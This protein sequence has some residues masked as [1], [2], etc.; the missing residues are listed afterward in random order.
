M[1]ISSGSAI[2]TA[3]GRSSPIRR[4]R[5]TS[6]RPGS[7]GSRTSSKASHYRVCLD[8]L[9]ARGIATPDESSRRPLLERRERGFLVNAGRLDEAIAATRAAVAR[10]DTRVAADPA[11]ERHLAG[12]WGDL[13]NLEGK[14]GRLTESRAAQEKSIAMFDRLVE[15]APSDA[16]LS[17]H[18]LTVL[19]N[20]ANS[21]AFADDAAARRA[22]ITTLVKRSGE[23]LDHFPAEPV[24][25]GRG[26]LL[27]LSLLADAEL[28]GGNA[29]A[30]FAHVERRAAMARRLAAEHPG[31][32]VFID[33]RV[34]A[35]VQGFHCL[36][37]LGRPGDARAGLEEAEA[38]AADAV[39]K[40]PS[41]LQRSW[42]L[43]EVL[44]VKAML[45]EA[46]GRRAEAL[47]EHRRLLDVILPW[48][49]DD[50]SPEP[51]PITSD[52]V[53]AQ[54]ERLEAE[55]RLASGAEE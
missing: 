37:A 53:R 47:A 8:E 25:F 30:A 21:P 34:A 39:A 26:L 7:T 36:R 22:L 54:I 3:T 15:A 55:E 20:A 19:Y 51:F 35:A 41:L 49:K 11:L 16:A 18:S 38:L 5:S 17:R 48:V 12:A 32:R 2:A 43:V 24:E 13:G 23:G 40:Q 28:R 42:V 50:G 52:G 1:P 6:A 4:P 46:T 10:L 33:D 14:A 27:G 29:A 45:E 44:A 31:E 9:E